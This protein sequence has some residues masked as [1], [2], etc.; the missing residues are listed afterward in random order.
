MNEG[1]T[2][3]ASWVLTKTDTPL[4]NKVSVEVGWI[5]FDETGRGKEL[6]KQPAVGR[7]LIMSPFNEFF[8]W[9]TTVVTSFQQSV[10]GDEIVFS[11]KNS[12]YTL[13]HKP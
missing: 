12:N 10:D 3:I 11:T 5:E 9:Q 13:K 6:H 8:T 1:T 4:F 2:P 7:S